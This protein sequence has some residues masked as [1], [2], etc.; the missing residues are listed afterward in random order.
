MLRRSEYKR[1]ATIS[2]SYKGWILIF[3]FSHSL[4]RELGGKKIQH[5]F[6]R[7]KDLST[8]SGNFREVERWGHNLPMKWFL[9]KRSTE[10]IK[11]HTLLQRGHF[12]MSL[13]TY[14]LFHGIL[15]KTYHSTVADY[16]GKFKERNLSTEKNLFHK[17]MKF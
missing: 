17:A 9:H 3:D 8:E 1:M 6:G 16:C 12:Q 4:L 13:W 10:L 2:G 15:R 14:I 5:N 11:L 7:K